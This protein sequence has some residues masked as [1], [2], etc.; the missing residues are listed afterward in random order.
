MS[1]RKYLT[2]EETFTDFFTVYKAHKQEHF[3]AIFG[4]VSNDDLTIMDFLL[5]DVFGERVVTKNMEKSFLEEGQ[6]T[7]TVRAVNAVDLLCYDNWLVLKS[8]LAKMSDFDIESPLTDTTEKTTEREGEQAT[9]NKENAFDDTENA[10]DTTACNENHSETVTETVA[11]HY[12][13]DKT[14][15]ERACSLIDF[16][17]NNDFLTIV[18]TDIADTI[19]LK[20]Y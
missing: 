8:N 6:E 9:Q 3:T 5:I 17:K 1:E 19:A 4:D 14:A 13:G 11:R 2:I 20:I 12:S 15:I 7:T 10:S 16:T 18:M